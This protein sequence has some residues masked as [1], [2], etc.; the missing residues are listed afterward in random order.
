MGWREL[1]QFENPGKNGNTGKNSGA[2]PDNL[3][4]LSGI[5]GELRSQ[6]ASESQTPPVQPVPGPIRLGPVSS[7]I[8]DP[9]AYR[10]RVTLASGEHFELHE[11]PEPTRARLE[12][13]Y[14]GATVEP[15]PD[16][17]QQAGQ[18][19]PPELDP[20]GWTDLVEDDEHRTALASPQESQEPNDGL[21]MLELFDKHRMA[22]SRIVRIEQVS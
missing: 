2:C 5:S 6:E 21:R 16:H 10:W 11:L 18:T 13:R 1:L 7:T 8:E 14:P 3:S 9:R 4:H 20:R 12:A 17:D 15:L 22:G 19:V